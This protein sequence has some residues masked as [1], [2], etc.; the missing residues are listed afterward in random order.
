MSM[1]VKQSVDPNPAWECQNVR[2]S[3][4]SIHVPLCWL[5]ALNRSEV[6]ELLIVNKHFSAVQL[7]DRAAFEMLSA[8]CSECSQSER[9]TIQT[10][11]CA[12]GDAT[13]IASANTRSES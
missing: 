6:T 2:M 13:L 11:P 3:E 7:V 12:R 5:R 10:V 4:T 8:S 1:E 9:E